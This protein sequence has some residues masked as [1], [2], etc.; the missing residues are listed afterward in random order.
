M[1]PS[2]V[3]A[4]HPALAGMAQRVLASSL[5]SQVMN[6]STSEHSIIAVYPT[7]ASA[8]GAVKLLKSGGLDMKR[9]SI[10]G[11]DFHSDKHALGFYTAGDRIK[12]WGGQGSVWG[13][14]WGMLFGGAFFFIP[15]I[16]PL[17]VMGPL[18]GWIVTALEGAP[19]GGAAGVLTVALSSIGI[20]RDSIVRYEHE[21]NTG[22]FLVLARGTAD[23]IEHARSIL[24][25]T[26]A[27]LMR[28]HPAAHNGDHPL[29]HQPEPRGPAF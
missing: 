26:N 7:H 3:G 22:H 21:L 19:V 14:V 24:R 12:F 20:P 6:Y 18:V 15:T 16:G 23:L 25:S 10:A 4:P 17:V 9:L 27:S 5:W 28:A 29:R 2:G 1:A 8:E 11:K 13:S